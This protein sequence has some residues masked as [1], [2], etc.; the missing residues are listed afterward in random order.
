MTEEHSNHCPGHGRREFLKKST[1]IAALGA[2]SPILIKAAEKDEYIAEFFEKVPLQIEINGVKHNL[3]VEPRVTLLDL[4][5][6]Q[7]GLTGTK[8]KA[9][10]MDNAV[11][12]LC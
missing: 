6:E 11:V 5:R 4:L 9:V 2:A 10:I 3:S 12:A 1:A 8:K 7:L